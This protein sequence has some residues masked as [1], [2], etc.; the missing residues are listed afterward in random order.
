MIIA[1]SVVGSNDCA[2]YLR[3]WKKPGVYLRTEDIRGMSINQRRQF[4]GLPPLNAE[5][6]A[7][8]NELNQEVFDN[9]KIIADRWVAIVSILPQLL[10]KHSDLFNPVELREMFRVH[11]D[12]MES[13]NDPQP[14]Q[15]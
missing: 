11:A 15:N 5:E 2:V 12:F 10:K 1:L 14:K 8:L 3:Q 7:E 9:L 6:L 13:I 4:D